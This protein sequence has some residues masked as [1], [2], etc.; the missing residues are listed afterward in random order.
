MNFPTEASTHHNISSLTSVFGWERV[1]PTYYDL[2]QVYR[3]LT[4]FK[5]CDY[6]KKFTLS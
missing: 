1:F 3:E 4:L 2:P 5:T 6:K